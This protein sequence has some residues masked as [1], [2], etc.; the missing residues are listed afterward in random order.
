VKDPTELEKMAQKIDSPAESNISTISGESLQYGEAEAPPWTDLYYGRKFAKESGAE[1]IYRGEA[2]NCWYHW[3]GRIWE[4]N[5]AL[6]REQV[7]SRM[8]LEDILRIPP[9]LADINKIRSKLTSIRFIKTTLEA[10]RSH[11]DIVDTDRWLFDSAH[12]LLNTP[13]GII[14]LKTGELGEHDPDCYITK[15]TAVSPDYEMK[16][17]AWDKFI[18][19]IFMG[20]GA[21]IDCVYRWLGYSL[22]G[23]VSEQEFVIGLG[24]Q[25]NGK[26]TLV[27]TMLHIMKDYGHVLNADAIKATKGS[28]RHTTDIAMTEGKRFIGTSEI[29]PGAYLN[30]PLIK[31][32]TG[33]SE[34]S[35]R[36]MH[37][38]AATIPVTAKIFLVANDILRFKGGDGAIERRIRAIPFDFEL[39]ED[40]IDVYM[41]IK[42]KKEAPGILAKIIPYSKAWYAESQVKKGALGGCAAMSRLKVQYL[43]EV[44]VFRTFAEECLEKAPRGGMT[45]TSIQDLY[46]D[47]SGEAGVSAEA[48]SHRLQKMGY[49][50]TRIRKDN[51]KQVR[52][53]RAKPKKEDGGR[54]YQEKH[55]PEH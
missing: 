34:I 44:D 53:L 50:K 37:K 43:A 26:S 18:D 41:D 55:D 22:T 2:L 4:V 12:H 38:D 21:L 52:G 1:F 30:A 51:G 29:E 27:K 39:D 11:P 36:C 13:E 35:A 31:N 45:N 6:E 10:A 47:W 19:Q 24:P 8:I 9:G 54:E 33:D 42:L 16:T 15:L 32:Y 23:E 25:G 28:P 14:N 40:N 7:A 46:L 3:N 48:L 20:D 49:Q 17:P 5:E